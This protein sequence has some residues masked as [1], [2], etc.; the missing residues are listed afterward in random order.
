MKNWYA[1]W[2]GTRDRYPEHFIETQEEK[3]CEK[4][5][6]HERHA[7][8]GYRYKKTLPCYGMVERAHVAYGTPV[9]YERAP[10][11]PHV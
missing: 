11:H 3:R 1:N 6:E 9:P 7:L 4:Q 8:Y 2:L 10:D 5:Q